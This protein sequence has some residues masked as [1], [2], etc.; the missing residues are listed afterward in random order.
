MAG[1]P[2]PPPPPRP[3]PR[4]RNTEGNKYE[5][6]GT[7]MQCTCGR[8]YSTQTAISHWECTLE[9]WTSSRWAVYTNTIN[10]ACLANCCRLQIWTNGILEHFTVIV[11][12]TLD[13]PKHVPRT[14]LPGS[15]YREHIWTGSLMLYK[16]AAWQDPPPPPPH[17]PPPDGSNPR[18]ATE[19]NNV[20]WLPFS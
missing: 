17:P 7:E 18:Y 6:Y 20:L 19:G 5:R 9:T 12:W 3:N 14:F 11:I 13:V 1:P 15:L 8:G 16:V 10:C 2:P 4:Y